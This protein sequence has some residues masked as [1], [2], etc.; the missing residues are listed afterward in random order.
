[1]WNRAGRFVMKLS[2]LPLVA[3]VWMASV[4]SGVALPGE[5]RPPPFCVG[6]ASVDIT[7]AIGAGQ[8]RGR[9]T[10][11]HDQLHAKALVFSQGNQQ[12]ALVMCDLCKVWPDLSEAVRREA[13][14]KTGI[15]LAN[16][17]ITAT[18]T[19]TGPL[20]RTDLDGFIHKIAKVIIDAHTTVRPVVLQTMTVRQQGIAFNR[21]YFMKNSTVQF[22]PGFQNPDIVRPAGPTDPEVG[23]LLFGSANDRVPIASL[24][25]FAMHLD[26]VGG[27]KYSADYPFFLSESLRKELGEDLVSLFGTSPCGNVNH[28]DV[29]G[30][31]PM[32]GHEGV[33][34]H[35]GRTL[36]TTIHAALPDLATI[37]RPCLAVRSRVV[38]VPLQHYSR[39]DLVW[40]R[41][42][43]DDTRQL[44]FLR[45][46]KRDRI[47]SLEAMRKEGETMP[48][49]VQVFRLSDRVAIVTLPGEIFVELGMAVKKGSPFSTTLVIELANDGS[50]NYIPNRVAFSQG[51]Y[52]V[53]NSRLAPGGGEVLVD[54]ALQLL[55]ELAPES[56]E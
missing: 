31:R 41:R 29:S 1:M 22:N 5:D 56:D 32:P 14:G 50:P 37:H 6:A 45:Q 24:T 20:Y 27:L 10:G 12:A 2:L 26:T 19:H 28:F 7:P 55:Q 42:V 4:L 38:Q 13:S 9:S 54:A 40:A 51:G 43:R 53:I 46:M 11:V 49:E 3:A 35:I 21:R 17:S 52:E 39:E 25:T 15:P 16:I 23:F 34:R 8:H 44:S 36:G 18:H 33:T 30:P 48:L 47:L